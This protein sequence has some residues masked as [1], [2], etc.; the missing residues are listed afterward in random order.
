MQHGQ[1][2]GL[3]TTG[4]GGH[5]DC[6]ATPRRGRVRVTLVRL[7]RQAPGEAHAEHHRQPYPALTQAFTLRERCK[8]GRA[9]HSRP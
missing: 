4:T 2:F 7:E 9:G 8:N 5:A 1:I 6:D 3:V